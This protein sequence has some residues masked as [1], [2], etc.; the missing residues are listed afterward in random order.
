MPIRVFPPNYQ[1][2][3]I[4]FDISSFSLISYEGTFVLSRGYVCPFTRVQLYFY[5]STFFFSRMHIKTTTHKCLYIVV[6]YVFI[7]F[8]SLKTILFFNEL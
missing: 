8:Y 1:L 5:D 4:N 2:V 6:I 3:Y 7:H